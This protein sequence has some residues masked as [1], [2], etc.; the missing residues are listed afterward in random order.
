VG[1]WWLGF[2]VSSI[3][4]FIVSLL[5][6]TF[7]ESLV[8]CRAELARERERKQKEKRQRKKSQWEEAIERKLQPY[9]DG[10]NNNNNNNKVLSS[11]PSS[12]S[13]VI[14]ADMTLGSNGEPL[15]EHVNIKRRYLHTINEHNGD[16]DEDTA[17]DVGN[18]AAIVEQNI[19]Y[20]ESVSARVSPSYAAAADSVS[21]SI[22]TSNSSSAAVSY[23]VGAGVANSDTNSYDMIAQSSPGKK[24]KKKRAVGEKRSAKRELFDKLTQLKLKFMG[25]KN[26]E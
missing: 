9:D 22:S 21:N 25:K 24:Q 6:V 20:M 18:E 23:I 11:P 5:M 17:N 4:M 10:N 16:D 2:I 14:R 13:I 19:D 15:K 8:R 26:S 7:P 1:A 3:L 12:S